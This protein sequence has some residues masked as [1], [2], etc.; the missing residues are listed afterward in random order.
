MLKAQKLVGTEALCRRCLSCTCTITLPRALLQT[1]A[2][3]VCLIIQS[4]L[5]RTRNIAPNRLPTAQW[6]SA[7]GS[8]RSGGQSCILVPRARLG[9]AAPSTL[10]STCSCAL[11]ARNVPQICAECRVERHAARFTLVWQSDTCIHIV[12]RKIRACRC[13]YGYY[14]TATFGL[15]SAA[16]KP[17]ITL[18]QMTQF[19]ALISQV[20]QRPPLIRYCRVFAQQFCSAW[21]CVNLMPCGVSLQHGKPGCA[22]LRAER[23]AAVHQG[24][25]PAAAV[26]VDAPGTVHG[27]LRPLRGLLPPGIPA[28]G[29]GAG[30]E[31]AAQR[32]SPQR[33]GPAQERLSGAGS[34]GAAAK[35]GACTT[36]VLDCVSGCHAPA[37]HEAQRRGS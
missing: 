4:L 2:K 16:V 12:I 10:R 33:R 31:S 3:F 24:L 6:D 34:K 29:A 22:L 30:G 9:F 27:L 37:Q 15:R 13:R 1:L 28:E 19:L 20:P 18:S 21:V 14:F 35:Q 23:L 11:K 7:A 26:A 25:L 5:R 17:L 8:F 32:H 36:W